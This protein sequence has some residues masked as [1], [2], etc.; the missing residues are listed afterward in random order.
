MLTDAQIRHYHEDGFVIPDFG[1]S[2]Q[3]LEDIRAIHTRLIERHPKFV[4]YCGAVLGYD[5]GFLN[6]A[7]NPDILDMI[8]QLLGDDIA[9]WNSSFFAKPARS[10][11]KTPWHQDGQYWPMRPIAT[12]SVWMA[13]D[14]STREN[15]C[16]RVIRGSHRDKSLRQHQRN[17]SPDL[18]LNQ[19][20][21]RCEFD[22][23]K[24]VDLEM[25]AGSDLA[26]RCLSRA[27]LRRPTIPTNRVVV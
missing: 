14:D 13:V 19:E 10:G 8:A 27:R 4:D 16:L 17:D 11:R 22:E 15:G 3:T 23:S 25:E 6:F 1:L 24:A 2:E 21:P 7:R 5:L 9:I 26:P 20:L 18:S 12:C